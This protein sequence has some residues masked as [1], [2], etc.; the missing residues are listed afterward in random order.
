MKYKTEDIIKDPSKV[1]HVDLSKHASKRV[2]KLFKEARERIEKNIRQ[3]K[4]S[5]LL[6]RFWF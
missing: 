3:S 6:D 2:K 4:H 5:N 1:K